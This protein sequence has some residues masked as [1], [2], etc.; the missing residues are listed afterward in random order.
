[1]LGQINREEGPVAQADYRS[2]PEAFGDAATSQLLVEPLVHR[3]IELAIVTLNRPEHRNPIDKDTATEL[4]AT[5]SELEQPNGPRGVVLTGAAD[6]FSAGGNMKGYVEL[7]KD[8]ERFRRFLD[9]FDA[10]CELLERSRLVTVAMVNGVCVAGGLEIALACDFITIA[11]SAH[12]GDGHLKFAQLPGG[13][14][15]QRLVRALGVSRAR[16][17]LLSGQ[18]YPAETAVAHGLATFAAPSSALRERTFDLLAEVCTA[19]PL[20]LERMKSLIGLAQEL[21][22]GAGIQEETEIVHKYATQ[23]YDA[24]EGLRAFAERRPPRYLGE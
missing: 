5:L 3:G 18:L 12:I 11:E 7:Y 16:Q 20:A 8:P 1:V 14:G 6:A 24:T 17:W 10:V 15:S 19:S 21:P 9:E 23:S 2:E 22:L 4:L 13:G